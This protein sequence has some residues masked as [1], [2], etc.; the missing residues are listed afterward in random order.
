MRTG[1]GVKCLIGNVLAKESILVVVF[2][3]PLSDNQSCMEFID[4]E[5]N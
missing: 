4:P 3:I 2:S 1:K 5:F